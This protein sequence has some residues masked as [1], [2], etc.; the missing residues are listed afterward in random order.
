MEGNHKASVGEEG[1][2]GVANDSDKQT[3]RLKS[4]LSHFVRPPLD[5]FMAFP[6]TRKPSKNSLGSMRGSNVAGKF[7]DCLSYNRQLPCVCVCGLLG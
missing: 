7:E 2:R 1:G 6:S 3:I 4:A 5:I